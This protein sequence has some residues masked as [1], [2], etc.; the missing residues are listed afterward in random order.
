M[1]ITPINP[2]V[3]PMLDPERR[4]VEE[5]AAIVR[6][7]VVTYGSVPELSVLCLHGAS[8]EPNEKAYNVGY[9][10]PGHRSKTEAYGIAIGLL[11]KSLAG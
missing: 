5:L 10:A 11:T 6:D 4:I 9:Y 3:V 1:N 7:Y 2:G 8:G